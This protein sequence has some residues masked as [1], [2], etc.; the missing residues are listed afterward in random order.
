MLDFFYLFVTIM[1]MIRYYG[2]VLVLLGF[3]KC[4][5]CFYSFYIVNV[6]SKHVYTILIERKKNL[7][8]CLTF[9]TQTGF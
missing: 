9:L 2:T 3:F 4:F 6:V 8:K 1:L 5:F 7:H